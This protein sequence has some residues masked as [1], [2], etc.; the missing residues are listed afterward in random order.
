[1]H[2][3]N[4]LNTAKRKIIKHPSKNNFKS[5]EKLQLEFTDSAEFDRISFINGAS[6]NTLA[7]CCTL[8]NSLKTNMYP[9]VMRHEDNR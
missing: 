8:L 9:L 1:M 2:A 7:E 4:K 3:L 5:V 6:T